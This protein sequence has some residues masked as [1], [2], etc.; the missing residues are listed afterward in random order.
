MA[1]RIPT[2]DAPNVASAPMPTPYENPNVPSG[3]AGGLALASEAL[4]GVAKV[5]QKFKHDAD[6]QAILGAQNAFRSYTDAGLEEVRRAE[7]VNAAAAANKFYADADKKAKDI[8]GGLVNEEQKL[9]FSNWANDELRQTR[10]I[11]ESHVGDQIK[12]A[13]ALEFNGANAGGLDRVVKSPLVP[14]LAETEA[15]ELRR[16]IYGYEENGVRVSG[17]AARHGIPKD[18]ADSLFAEKV[19]VIYAAKAERL[20]DLGFIQ[21][22]QSVVEQHRNEL[23][24]NADEL[25]KRVEALS[26]NAR[27]DATAEQLAKKYAFVDGTV[28]STKALAEIDSTMQAGQERDATRLA[29]MHRADQ[30]KTGR[31]SYEADVWDKV[32][33]EY[34]NNGQSLWAA[35]HSPFWSKATPDQQEKLRSRARADAREANSQPL[36]EDQLRSYGRL[37][38]DVIERQTFWGTADVSALNQDSDY[39]NLPV[40]YREHIR[41]MVAQ[42][43]KDRQNPEQQ[44]RLSEA[45]IR[46]RAQS[47]GILSN[48]TRKKR[49]FNSWKDDDKE[50]FLTIQDRVADKLSN[51]YSDKNNSGKRIPNELV[52]RY[53]DDATREGYLKDGRWYWT[54]P[55]ASAFDAALRKPAEVSEHPFVPILQHD[56]E[57]VGR[58]VQMRRGF[59][60]NKT[61]AAFTPD[62]LQR[63]AREHAEASAGPG[64]QER[65][66]IVGALKAA[67]AKNPQDPDLIQSAYEKR[68]LRYVR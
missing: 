61:P 7:G 41:T 66:V 31:L 2:L 46:E 45:V 60:E 36:T 58:Q 5:E 19:S 17:Y 30:A 15:D 38:N 32:A 24:K 39:N 64:P 53:V 63:A 20:M 37:M 67:G 23:G 22:A 40:R 65:E 54:D 11:G 13:D 14:G 16:R 44:M 47:N 51:W 21:Q 43:H 57:D 6:G 29:L 9:A 18:A 48:D 4:S 55:K 42:T 27:A 68:H 35:V 49:D 1:I 59:D 33:G 62:T 52:Q 10:K 25:M 34:E 28:D 26:R 50:A 56:E 3:A 12:S 8:F